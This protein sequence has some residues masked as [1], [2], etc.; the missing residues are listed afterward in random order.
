[1]YFLLSGLLA[2]G[3]LVRLALTLEAH[4]GIF[5]IY[6]DLNLTSPSWSFFSTLQQNTTISPFSFNTNFILFSSPRLA[7]TLHLFSYH[8]IK[9][10]ASTKGLLLPQTR[11]GPLLC[12]FP[13]PHSPSAG[14]SS[15]KIPEYDSEGKLVVWPPA[16]MWD[17]VLLYPERCK[18]LDSPALLSAHVSLLGLKYYRK[19]IGLVLVGVLVQLLRSSKYS[20]CASGWSLLF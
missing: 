6:K 8:R 11:E 16:Q 3:S 12:M 10:F 15:C 9:D 5:S 2:P 20:F 7:E 1:M 18:V 17:S 14:T 13:C 4:R 19:W